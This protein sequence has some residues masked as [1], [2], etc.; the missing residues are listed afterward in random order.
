M[1]LSHITAIN[2]RGSPCMIGLDIGGTKMACCV[3]TPDGKAHA[4]FKQPTEA[5]RG[6]AAV[7]ADAWQLVK[8]MDDA[9]RSLDLVP[10]VL[11]IAICELVDLEGQIVSEHTVAWQDHGFVGRFDDFL[12]TFVEADC[13]AAAIA[14]SRF[15]AGREFPIFLYVTVG[16]G[17][18]CSLVIDGKP[19]KGA[20]GATGTM[21]TGDLSTLCN[22]CG[23]MGSSNL[24]QTASGTAVSRRYRLEA[25]RLGFLGGH[26]DNGITAE[27]VIARAQSGDVVAERVLNQGAICLGSTVAQLVNV[28]D[29]HA[30]IIGGGLGSAPGYYWETLINTTRRQIWSD[31]HRSLPIVQGKLGELAAAIGAALFAAEQIDKRDSR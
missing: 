5:A 13:R 18:S 30:V 8:T 20:T 3:V 24:E 12:P 11:G 15:G 21:A 23:E 1:T 25:E 9:A 6:G 4:S 7:A 29:P 22:V 17:I 10:D 26:R 27:Q 19:Y 14:E 16:T 2:G 31:T 28:L